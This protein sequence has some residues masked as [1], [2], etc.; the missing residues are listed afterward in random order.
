[1][2][3]PI[4]LL[5]ALFFLFTGC[6][7]E[8]ERLIKKGYPKMYAEGYQDGCYTGNGEAG[9][10]GSFEKNPKFF[11]LDEQYTKGWYEGHRYCFNEVKSMQDRDLKNAIEHK[12]YEKNKD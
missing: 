9:G 4:L 11:D 2:I 3:R 10:F 5:S 6:L 7:S 1:M 8:K 12:L